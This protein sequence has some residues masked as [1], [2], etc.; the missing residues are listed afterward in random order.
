MLDIESI[1]GWESIHLLCKATMRT[2]RTR[3]NP[4]QRKEHERRID[5]ERENILRPGLFSVPRHGHVLMT[6]ERRKGEE[7]SLI[8]K[9]LELADIALSRESKKDEAA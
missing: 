5:R 6:K 7:R 3:K 2:S 8:G 4:A 1:L 9:Y